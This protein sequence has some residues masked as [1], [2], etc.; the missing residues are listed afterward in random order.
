LLTK[1]TADY[2]NYDVWDSY[3][4]TNNTAVWPGVTQDGTDYHYPFNFE[5]AQ[6]DDDGNIRLDIFHDVNTKTKD[7][8][9]VSSDTDADKS[10]YVKTYDDGKEYFNVAHYLE[11]ALGPYLNPG[12]EQ[13]MYQQKMM[14]LC[15]LFKER[16][17]QVFWDGSTNPHYPL[18]FNGSLYPLNNTGLDD[19][20]K[21]DRNSKFNSTDI[22]NAYIN[23]HP[24]KNDKE[25][26]RSIIRPCTSY[27]ALTSYNKSKYVYRYNYSPL[28]PADTVPFIDQHVE[29]HFY[30]TQIKSSD[31][32]NF[33]RYDIEH[34]MNKVDVTIFW[35]FFSFG[36]FIVVVVVY[37][38]TD[39]K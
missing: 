17:S 36:L 21:Y 26:R 27:G 34:Y 15:L 2:D 28:I 24:G 5:K 9:I 20:W 31:L 1:N 33:Y 19:V 6:R 37:T 18:V 23:T 38:K 25:T 29:L 22:I 3:E 39:F 8:N 12:D 30:Y 13:K 14:K 10:K 7:L 16:W 35:A 11:K 4:V 32:E